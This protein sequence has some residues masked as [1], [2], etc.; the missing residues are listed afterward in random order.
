MYRTFSFD[1]VNKILV[2]FVDCDCGGGGGGG[3]GAGGE[4]VR[5]S[6]EV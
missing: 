5:F 3:A 4:V 6:I 2:V 1:S